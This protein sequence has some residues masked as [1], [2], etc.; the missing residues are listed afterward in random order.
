MAWPAP[1]GGPSVLSGFDPVVNLRSV[2][3][4]SPPPGSKLESLAAAP[5]E[6]SDRLPALCK[7]SRDSRP[8]K[9]GGLSAMREYGKSGRVSVAGLHLRGALMGVG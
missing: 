3:A 7:G 9:P 1:A 8:I 2:V 4:S 5:H 6:M